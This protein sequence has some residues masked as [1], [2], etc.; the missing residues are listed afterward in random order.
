MTIRW[1]AD[2]HLNGA[3]AISLHPAQQLIDKPPITIGGKF[4][5]A[6]DRHCLTHAPEK[7][8]K[9]KI[10]ELRFNTPKRNIDRR[11]RRGTDASPAYIAYGAHHL[12][13]YLRNMEGVR[14]L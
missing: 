14:I 7:T 2:L 4:A 5:T 8:N 12:C 11:D 6:V 9:G 3:T 1:P 10:E 13:P